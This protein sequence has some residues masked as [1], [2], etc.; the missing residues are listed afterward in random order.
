M[1]GRKCVEGFWLSEWLRG[2]RPLRLLRLFGTVRDLMRAGVLTS[3]V[4][5]TFPLEEV[6]KAAA[7]AE[8]P[9]RQGKVLLRFS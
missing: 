5:A 9:G 4:G 7:Q 2:Q 6:Q 1:V 3:E 8:Q